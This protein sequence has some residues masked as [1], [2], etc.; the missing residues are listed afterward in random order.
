[1]NQQRLYNDDTF[2][3]KGYAFRVRFERDEHM[4]EPWKEHDGHG[5][6]SEWTTRDKRPGERLLHEDHGSKRYYDAQAALRL[7]KK[8]GWGCGDETHTHRTAGEKAACAVERD[9]DYLRRWCK[10]EWEWT[11]VIVEQVD[12]DGDPTG[13]KDSLWGIDGDHG[14]YLTTVAYELADEIVNQ[15]EVEQPDAV[16]SEN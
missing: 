8:D 16:L 5:P 11:G 12:E 13:E 2:T 14:G 1:M 7:A 3:H 4:G 9:F 10:D 15:L 6:V